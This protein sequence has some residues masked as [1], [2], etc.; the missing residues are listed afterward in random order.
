MRCAGVVWEACEDKG[1]ARIR[2]GVAAGIKPPMAMSREE[3]ACVGCAPVCGP[4]SLFPSSLE[5][6]PP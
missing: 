6:S 5:H 4:A 2:A 1:A 3:E